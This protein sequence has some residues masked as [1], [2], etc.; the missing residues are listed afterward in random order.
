MTCCPRAR[1]GYANISPACTPRCL[2]LSRA[3]RIHCI[4]SGEE[5]IEPVALARGEDTPVLFTL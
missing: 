4:P 2:L 5:F 1:G 3:G